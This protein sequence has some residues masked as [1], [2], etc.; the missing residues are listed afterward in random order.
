[1]KWT[2]NKTILITGATNGIGK[3]AAIKFAESAKSIA[4]TYRN[5]ELAEDLK[6]EMQKINPNLSINSFFCDFSV[7]DSIRECADKIKNDL[8]AIDLLINN[9]GV[10]NTEYTETIDGIENTFAVNH[11]GYFLFTNLLLDLVKKESESRIINVSSAAHHFVK[12]MQWDD[13]NYKDDFK[14][15]LKAY[16]QS[17]LGNILFTKQLAKKLQKDGV[18]VNAIHPGGVNTSL[19]NQNNSLLGRVLKIILKP[20]FRSPLKGA[21]TIIYLA[22]IDGLSITGA[23]WVDGRVAKT[24]HYSKNEAEAE[25]LWRLS[26]KLVN[27]EFDI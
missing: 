9:A 22:E 10:V 7:Q 11:L 17:K 27:Q 6:N 2:N 14:M 12:G 13:I 16:G 24:S 8:K 19:G 20:F 5:E 23:Y 15:G 26:E 25:K 21:N 3:A 1:M 18:T 4:F